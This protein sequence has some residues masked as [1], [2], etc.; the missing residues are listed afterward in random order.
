MNEADR[1]ERLKKL[2][3]SQRALLAQ[4]LQERKATAAPAAGTG[5]PRRAGTAPVLLSSGQRRMW[6][7]QRMDPESPDANILVPL[8]LDESATSA[9]SPQ[10]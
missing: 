9:P 8:R 2:S 3:R 5:I 1:L 7:A 4:R 6:L 10:G